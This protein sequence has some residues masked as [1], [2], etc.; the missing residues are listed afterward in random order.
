[1]Q[2]DADVQADGAPSSQP[3]KVQNKDDGKAEGQFS[4][5][6]IALL[7]DTLTSRPRENRL[8]MDRIQQMKDKQ[9][10]RK[11]AENILAS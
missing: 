2:T 8:D 11:R 9:V 4:S 1:M 5:E 10:L 7:A 6:H 3:S